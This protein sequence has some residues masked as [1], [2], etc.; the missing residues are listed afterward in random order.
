VGIEYLC[1]I[2]LV[3]EGHVSKDWISE[4][5]L[6]IPVGSI[7]VVDLAIRYF[8]TIVKSLCLVQ[9]FKGW[10]AMLLSLTQIKAARLVGH[11]NEHQRGK[12]FRKV[13]YELA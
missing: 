2:G 10:I 9:L 7:C 8:T 6:R 1:G 4:G 12:I 5:G 13:V 3:K 11:R